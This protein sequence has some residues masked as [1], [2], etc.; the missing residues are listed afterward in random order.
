MNNKIGLLLEGGGF[1]GI[2]SAGVLDYFLEQ[3]IE[4]PYV[5]GVSMGACNGA[6]YI[7]KQ[8]GRNLS[9]PYNYI[10]DSRY[11]SYKRLITKGELFGM[12]FIFSEIPQKLIPF[13]FD[14]FNVSQQ[15]FVV[16]TADCETGEPFYISDFIKY[17]V[18]EATKASI[19]LPFVSKMVSIQN[20]KLLDGGICD[21]IPIDK[22]FAD[23]CDKLVIVL[24]QP[25]GFRKKASDISQFT[26]L[27]YK[28]YPKLVE[29]FNN[30]Y[31]V[32]N[33]ALDQ[34]EELELAGK[35][36]VIRPEL[37]V[38]ISRTEKNKEK[39]KAAFEMGY[40]QCDDF[41]DG[42]REFIM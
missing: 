37:K 9:I 19:S 34:I 6:N 26:K 10:N 12:D 32:Y 28:R 33:E 30:R 22:A 25:K 3:N 11:M 24:T 14:T 39:L 5:I 27:W 20:R 40:Q 36:F 8:H 4:F 7:S 17:D 16:V 18:L 23:G 2:Y 42:L 13:D 35:V 1:R 31:K 38:P 41:I 15:K 21:P 29:A